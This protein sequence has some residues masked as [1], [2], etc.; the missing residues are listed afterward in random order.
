MAVDP[1]DPRSVMERGAERGQREAEMAALPDP[2]ELTLVA[3][4]PT[5]ADHG[6]RLRD[7][8]ILASVPIRDAAARRA[9]FAALRRAILDG[10]EQALCFH[11]RHGLRAVAAGVP[12]D[13][14]LCFECSAARLHARGTVVSF[15][16]AP[17]LK[18]RLDALLPPSP[19]SK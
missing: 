5:P 11:P 12:F 14:L 17:S 4:S 6:E 3:L 16:L 2:D 18:P 8:P 15:P 7:Y 19:P 13:I 10:D 1:R 9:L